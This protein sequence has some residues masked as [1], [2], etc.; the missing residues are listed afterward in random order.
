MCVRADDAVVINATK[1]E[2]VQ[3]EIMQVVLFE[4][5]ESYKPEVVLALPNESTAQLQSNAAAIVARIRGLL[6]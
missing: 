2:N 5:Q 6:Q 4:A 1:Q 3:A